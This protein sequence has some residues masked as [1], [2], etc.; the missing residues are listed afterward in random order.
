MNNSKKQARHWIPEPV[1]QEDIIYR[2]C[3]RCGIDVRPQAGRPRNCRDCYELEMNALQDAHYDRLVEG[4]AAGVSQRD[5]AARFGVS[6]TTVQKWC[7][8]IRQQEEVLV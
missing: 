5:M 2:L 1:R 7:R 6:R 3:N 4:M 8:A